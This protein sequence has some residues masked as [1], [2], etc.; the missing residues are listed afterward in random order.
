MR[1]DSRNLRSV[2]EQAMSKVAFLEGD[3][4]V[5]PIFKTLMHQML[6][7]LLAQYLLFYAAH[8]KSKGTAFYADHN[9]FERLYGV[10]KGEVDDLAEKI[11]GYHGTEAINIVELV[12]GAMGWLQSWEMGDEYESALKSEE[13]MQQLFRQVYE[14]LKAT[15]A[16]PLGLDDWMM[17]AANAH[18]THTYL[19]QQRLRD[20]GRVADKTTSAQ[21]V[22]QHAA[23]QAAQSAPMGMP[24]EEMG[25]G[26]PVPMEAEPPMPPAGP[27]IAGP[28]VGGLPPAA[29]AKAPPKPKTEAKP[30]DEKAPPAKKPEEKKEPP[31]KVA[32]IID[33]YTRVLGG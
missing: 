10:V 22:S 19:L 11:V 12:S 16:L 25:A 1:Y 27:P 18:E 21:L 28:P 30:K 13:A 9:L 17:S 5:Q 7:L 20:P 8:W 3:P 4:Q 15:G 29:P 23:A 14:Q 32:H 31:P 33:L 24:P 2:Y 26:A 6:T